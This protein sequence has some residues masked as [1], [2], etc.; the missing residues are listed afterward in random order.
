MRL[1]VSTDTANRNFKR[2]F[3]P[4]I[5][6]SLSR[7]NVNRH[8]TREWLVKISLF[9]A[10]FEACVR[11]QRLIS[12]PSGRSLECRPSEIAGSICKLVSGEGS[13]RLEQMAQGQPLES[14]RGGARVGLIRNVMITR[15]FT[16]RRPASRART[17]RSVAAK[18]RGRG[19]RSRERH[20]TRL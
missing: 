18:T 1:R 11:P 3:W 10:C 12:S 9:R 5:N 4:I 8:Q 17:Q 6:V 14:L 19:C 2:P 15:W 7:R 16:R 20:R 13:S